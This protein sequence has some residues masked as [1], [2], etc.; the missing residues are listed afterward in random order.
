MPTRLANIDWS[1]ISLNI[2]S[3][4]ALAEEFL[5]EHTEGWAVGLLI[6]SIAILNFAKAYVNVRDGNKKPKK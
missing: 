6:V 5:K 2:L 1:F 4:G 3:G